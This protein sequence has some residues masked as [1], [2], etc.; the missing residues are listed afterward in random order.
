MHKSVG[1]FST[2]IRAADNIVIDNLC[3]GYESELNIVSTYGISGI[4]DLKLVN[5]S[6]D[7]VSS[8]KVNVVPDDVK[9][10]GYSDLNIENYCVPPEWSEEFEFNPINGKLTLK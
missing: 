9:K 2:K 3:I 5:V 8:L 7:E 4:Q 1:S 10:S 6:V